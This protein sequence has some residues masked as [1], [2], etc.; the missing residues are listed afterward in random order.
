MSRIEV[1]TL[2]KACTNTELG[3]LLHAWE[4]GFLDEKESEEFEV[5][6]L[7]CDYCNDKALE[8]R[9]E[10]VLMRRS[11]EARDT[12]HDICPI[13]SDKKKTSN[14]FRLA[15]I[16]A[17]VVI[18]ILAIYS[19]LSRSGAQRASQELRL[20][21]MR[22]SSTNV[23]KAEFPGNVRI[24]FVLGGA[25]A[26]RTYKLSV[27]DDHGETLWTNPQFADFNSSGLGEIYLPTDSLKVGVYTLEIAFPDRPA[28]LQ[29]YHF[30]AE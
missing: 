4:L 17:T 3:K 28:P 21:P 9:D 8:L 27:I 7:D 20:Y 24:K 23:I 10:M 22:S 30:R 6:L 12:I 2:T 29:I 18:M 5:H 13:D 19:F 14:L 16:A 15:A 26:G 1:W 25:V 11:D